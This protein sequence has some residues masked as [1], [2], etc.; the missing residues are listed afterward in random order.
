MSKDYRGGI[1]RDFLL[2]GGFDLLCSL[3][4]I[5][6]GLYIENN[7][8]YRGI[9]FILLGVILLL[10]LLVMFFNNLKT[11]ISISKEGVL[12]EKGK[13]LYK[14]NWGEMVAFYPPPEKK[15]YF[16]SAFLGD[17][18]HHF[19]ID[20]FTFPRF[21]EIVKELSARYKT[22]KS[23]SRGSRILKG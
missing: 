13:T 2:L 3:V 8:V 14:I 23:V 19:R 18:K 7:W 21:D 12:F 4:I 20:S 5:F 11:R 1:T 22:K 9:P 16:K 17:N 6:Y 15:R 10:V